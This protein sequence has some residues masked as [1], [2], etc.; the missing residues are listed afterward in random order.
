MGC[1][2]KWSSPMPILRKFSKYQGAGNDFILFED[3]EEDFPLNAVSSLCDRNFGIGADGLMLVRRSKKGGDFEMV[4]FNRDGSK[5]AMCGNGLRCFAHFLLDNRKKSPSYTIEIDGKLLTVKIDQSKISTFLEPV[6]VLKWAV[7]GYEWPLYLVDTGIRHLVIFAQEEV[8][9]V[10]RGEQLCHD[11]MLHAEG[12]NVNFAWSK[13]DDTFSVRT[14]EKGVEGETLA[15][16]TGAAAV[17]FVANRLGKVE[18]NV[19][20]VTRSKAVLSVHLEEEI[21]V[22]GPSSKVF[23]GTISI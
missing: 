3:F 6:K 13:G 2:T 23:E 21:E 5:G 14:F 15:C 4:F 8:D 18:K 19:D 20:I 9:V 11:N 22:I 7:E 12:V 17:A 1:S 10:S 16:G